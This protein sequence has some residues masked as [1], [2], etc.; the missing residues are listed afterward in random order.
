[1]L[2]RA[3]LTRS[4]KYIRI[5]NTNVIFT[6]KS[7]MRMPGGRQAA[8]SAKRGTRSLERWTGGRVADFKIGIKL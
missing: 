5:P 8:R 3:I 2:K 1:M 7:G 4:W 6:A